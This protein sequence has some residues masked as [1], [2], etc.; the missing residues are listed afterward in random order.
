MAKKKLIKNGD[1]TIVVRQYGD[2]QEVRN[3]LPS[4]E[5]EFALDLIMSGGMAS[6]KPPGAVVERAFD[7]SRLTYAHI[8]ANKMDT[9]FPFEKVYGDADA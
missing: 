7:I 5:A 1:R 8:K 9:P 6:E 3:R 4:N 2:V